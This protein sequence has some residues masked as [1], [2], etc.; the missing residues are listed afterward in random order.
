MTAS[1][2]T[3]AF[4]TIVPGSAADYVYDRIGA[5]RTT[6]LPQA[7]SWLLRVVGQVSNRNLLDSERLGAGGMDSVRGYYT[8]T[9]LGSEGVLVSNEIRSAVFSVTE[10]LH[11]ATPVKDAEQ[12][13]VFWDYGHVTQVQSVPNTINGADLS[14]VG[15]DVH[16]TLD[17]YVDVRHDLGAQLRNA[18][19]TSKRGVF[20]D[21][22]VV[23][24]Y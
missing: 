23:L 17:R 9:A 15:F 21:V 8:D 12:L 3:A 14:S 18:P 13:G 2:T 4:R 6:V 19:G 20:G 7:L 24:R 22:A 10:A 16:A 5:T 1:N 11:V